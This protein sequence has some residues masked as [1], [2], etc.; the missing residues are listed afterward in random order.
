[1][2]FTESLSPIDLGPIKEEPE[3]SDEELLEDMKAR[4]LTVT[5]SFPQ[6]TYQI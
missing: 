6:E 5:T 2:L 3:Y 4:L 1:M